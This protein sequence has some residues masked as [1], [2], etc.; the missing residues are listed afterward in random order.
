MFESA[1]T[2]LAV[3][4]LGFGLLATAALAGPADDAIKGRQ[5]CMKSH[6][7]VMAVAVPMM[8]GEK[9]FDAAALKTAS[10][11]E[12]EA[13]AAWDSFWGT[14]AQKGETAETWARP[15]IW[16]DNAAFQAAAGKW[17]EAAQKM[18]AAGDE[19]AFKASFPAVGAACQACH[20]KFR[21]PK[22]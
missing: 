9:P 19:S 22:G 7:G 15:E 17:W 10:D 16:A 18:R 8:K 2:V 5:A 13:C 14:E 11:K 4:A 21:R 12:D 20:E 6:A 1:K 3:S